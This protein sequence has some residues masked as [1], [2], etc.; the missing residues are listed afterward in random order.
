MVGV[1]E[2]KA[3]GLD[4]ERLGSGVRVRGA[5]IGE[6]PDGEGDGENEPHEGDR[7]QH[8]G[9][10]A[11]AVS[12]RRRRVVAAAVAAIAVGE[13]VA[14]NPVDDGEVEDEDEGERED[15]VRDEL[16]VGVDAV[17]EV[18]ERPRAAL[19]HAPLARHVHLVAGSQRC[20]RRL[21][22]RER[23]GI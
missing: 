8:V 18:V 5:G 7:E 23:Q 6:R 14:R 21:G 20:V 13:G 9:D 17:H 19:V 3:D 4:E 1:H 15:G 10:A 22:K 12:L 2:E 11:L 16:H